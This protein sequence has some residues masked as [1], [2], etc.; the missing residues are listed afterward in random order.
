M[1]SLTSFRIFANIKFLKFVINKL[2]YQSKK[3]YPTQK[4]HRKNVKFH[5]ISIEYM[6]YKI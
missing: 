4:V 6:S 2:V 5:E 3:C 1:V